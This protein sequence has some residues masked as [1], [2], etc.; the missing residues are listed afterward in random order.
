MLSITPVA[1]AK[2]RQSYLIDFVYNNQ[3]SDESFGTSPRDTANAI[4]IIEEY[5]AYLVEVLFELLEKIF[6]PKHLQQKMGK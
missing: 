3:R 2:T 4:E 6:V 1:L 5:N